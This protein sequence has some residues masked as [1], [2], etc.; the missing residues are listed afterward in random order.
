VNTACARACKRIDFYVCDRHICEG[1]DGRPIS[2]FRGRGS[3]GYDMLCSHPANPYGNNSSS[4]NT[5]NFGQAHVRKMVMDSLRYWKQDMRVDG[6]RFHLAS[7]FSRNA[8]ESLNWRDAPIFSE[9]AT[10]PEL[11]PLHLLATSWVNGAY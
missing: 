11:G 5:L 1:D 9:I 2:S 6:F 4:G 8:D 10:D 3:A 7:V